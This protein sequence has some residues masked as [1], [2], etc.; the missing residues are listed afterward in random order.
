MAGQNFK[1][2]QLNQVTLAGRCLRD[3]DLK[4]VGDKSTP[5]LTFGI[6][7]P[8]WTPKGEETLYIDVALW[9]KAAERL[10]GELVKGTPVIVTGKLVQENWETKDGQKRNK[11]KVNAMY[12]SSLVWP[13]GGDAP[14]K[15]QKKNEPA[16]PEY[17]DDVPF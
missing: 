15:R 3:G 13:D 7:V 4:Y 8:N 1:M 14:P 17:D 6:A 10:N 11:I 5:L 9:G 16:P 12:A 2:P